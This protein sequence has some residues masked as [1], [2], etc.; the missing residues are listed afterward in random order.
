MLNAGRLIENS[1]NS[2]P[3]QSQKR[4][5]SNNGDCECN[6]ASQNENPFSRY[7]RRAELINVKAEN[8]KLQLR[9]NSLNQELSELKAKAF[10]ERESFASDKQNFEL[11]NK[12]LVRQLTDIA[13]KHTSLEVHLKDVEKLAIEEKS[14]LSL[15][16][17]TTESMCSEKIREYE[18]TLDECKR[19]CEFLETNLLEKRHRV[20]Q[21]EISIEHLMSE[22]QFYKN[23]NFDLSARNVEIS[24]MLSA[25]Q[26]K[27]KEQEI[28]IRQWREDNQIASTLRHSADD[29]KRLS[30][31][32]ASLKEQIRKCKYVVDDVTQLMQ[33]KIFLEEEIQMLKT[34]V[35]RYIPKLA[36]LLKNAR[37]VFPSSPSSGQGNVLIRDDGS[38]GT[39]P[40]PAYI[41]YDDIFNQLN[42]TVNRMKD[43]GPVLSTRLKLQFIF[44]S[45]LL[46]DATSSNLSH[47]EFHNNDI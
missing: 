13:D 9:V 23:R 20:G 34:S 35:Q 44:N 45:L 22:M 11:M 2:F 42:K 38:T 26:R 28:A 46:D 27:L 17:K 5:K 14:T 32:N 41:Q 7:D 33:D 25:T 4:L 18:Q 47:K 30:L 12:N 10:R 36:I 37:W 15:N 40:V 3:P 19:H 1:E 31:E 16:M 21:L 39:G 24:N 29:F 6:T 8:A 43:T